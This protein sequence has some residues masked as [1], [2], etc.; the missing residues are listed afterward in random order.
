[1]TRQRTSK[2][3]LAALKIF[4]EQQN[5]QIVGGSFPKDTVAFCFNETLITNPFLDEKGLYEVDPVKYYG[6]AF[7][8]SDFM[9]VRIQDGNTKKGKQSDL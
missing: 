8:Q 9:K 6:S 5:K 7:L 1:M 3:F 2:K 4:G